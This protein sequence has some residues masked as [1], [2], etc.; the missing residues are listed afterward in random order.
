MTESEVAHIE[1]T[2]G[3]CLP[4][5][6][7]AVLA[8]NPFLGGPAPTF[9]YDEASSVIE[10]TLRNRRLG[11]GKHRWPAEY[12]VVGHN[13]RGGDFF[14]DLSFGD[15]VYE[16]EKGIF[17]LLWQPR[18]ALEQFWDETDVRLGWSH[19]RREKE[20]IVYTS[21]NPEIGE[22]NR[23]LHRI[24]EGKPTVA[25]TELKVEDL[26]VM[27]CVNSLE[28][29]LQRQPD[30]TAESVEAALAA[31]DE[32]IAFLPQDVAAI[33][34]RLAELFEAEELPGYAYECWERAHE[35][36]PDS[37]PRESLARWSPRRGEVR[38][39]G[40]GCSVLGL[41]IGPEFPDVSCFLDGLGHWM[42]KGETTWV[43]GQL[44]R[45]A[46]NAEEVGA[47]GAAM[48][49]YTA[50]GEV[51]GDVCAPLTRLSAAG[52]PLK[53]RLLSFVRQLL[54]DPQ[55][56]SPLWKQFSSGRLPHRAPRKTLERGHK[57]MQADERKVGAFLDKVY[58]KLSRMNLAGLP[59]WEQFVSEAAPH[60]KLQELARSSQTVGIA[61]CRDTLA[62][63]RGLSCGSGAS[64][65]EVLAQAGDLLARHGLAVKCEGLPDGTPA[66]VMAELNSLLAQAS[67][68]WEFVELSGDEPAW[69]LATSAE[70]VKLRSSSLCK[71][72]RKK[73]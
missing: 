53:G 3:V 13:G 34:G 42:H 11:F 21:Q 18:A 26:R 40:T 9:L 17:D 14:L 2:L 45:A 35:L 16:A 60:E 49:F 28:V 58:A 6:Y 24:L 47:V 73:S 7:S 46:R 68:E 15:M 29:V 37:V 27:L 61:E 5:S 50:A 62:Y 56:V 63:M 36:D 41:M 59:A 23:R 20:Q 31:A 1:Q 25:G 66:R 4:P 51:G 33:Y 69:V 71:R 12:V 52:V 22:L 32:I 8:H 39:V 43:A 54:A 30:L 67:Q 70:A 10:H 64:P 38:T 44:S 65:D 72:S 55:E 48:A 57:R 19:E